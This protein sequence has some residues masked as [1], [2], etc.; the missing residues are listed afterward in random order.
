MAEPQ[1]GIGRGLAAILTVTPRET[2]EELRQ[3]IDQTRT[4]VAATIQE[5]GLQQDQ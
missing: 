1:R 4:D 3:V 5:F 2:P